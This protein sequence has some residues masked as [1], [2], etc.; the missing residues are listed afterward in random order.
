MPDLGAAA[1]PK[2][3]RLLVLGGTGFIGPHIIEAALAKGWE[4]TMFN[5][6]KTHPELFPEVERLV[7]DRDGKLDALRGGKWDAVVDTSGY[8]PRIVRDSATLLKDAVEQYVFVSSISAYADFAAANIEETHALATMPDPTVEDVMP[9]YGALKALCEQAAEAA[10]PG[11]TTN[12]RPGFIVGP[13]DPT[14][15]FTYW[16][17]RVA[18][19]GTMIAPG[20]PADPVQ[21][22]DARDLAAWIIG[23]IEN[24]H[25]GT[26]NLVGPQTPMPVG[27]LLSQCLEVT[28]ADTKLE[29]V[30]TEF[31][32]ANEVTPGGDM[33]IWIP[34]EGESLGFGQVSNARA[35][36]T[37]LTFRPARDTIAD[38]LAWFATLPAERQ[39]KLRAGLTAEREAK[40]LAAW[41]GRGKTK[42]KGKGKRSKAA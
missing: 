30:P 28:K 1:K 4:V 33:P 12:V 7:G 16:P 11:R 42:P 15:R 34:P 21:F 29:W 18:R 14:D 24:R 3:R 32:V 2:A 41:Q 6:G 40:V 35:V 13:L 22:I 23:A 25:V 36:A 26:Y 19:G 17:V 39:A 37:G 20:T 31:L 8:V 27:D 9:F 38:T 5:R 10:L